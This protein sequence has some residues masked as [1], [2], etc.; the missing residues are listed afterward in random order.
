MCMLCEGSSQSLI[1]AMEAGACL[2]W[3]AGS[4]LG[5]P[6]CC[7]NTSQLLLQGASANNLEED[8]RASSWGSALINDLRMSCRPWV[9][10]SRTWHWPQLQRN[11]KLWNPNFL[12][13][14]HFYIF[15]LIKTKNKYKYMHSLPCYHNKAS[16][17]WQQFFMLHFAVFPSRPMTLTFFSLHPDLLSIPTDWTSHNSTSHLASIYHT[18]LC[19]CNL[20]GGQE[21]S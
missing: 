1:S 12:L 6:L 3:G 18:P 13:Q 21:R 10:S 7:Q 4:L 9:D 19:V 11:G 16:L 15:K 5:K 20:V 8:G 14:T 2:H 17:Y